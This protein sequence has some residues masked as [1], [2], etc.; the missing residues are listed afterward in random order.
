MARIEVDIYDVIK[1][2]VLKKELQERVGIK[3]SYAYIVNL[4]LEHLEANI[5]Q[6]FSIEQLEKT[7]WKE[8]HDRW[9]TK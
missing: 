3:V 5:G 7:T 4:A 6:G 1:M 2:N 8:R 9:N